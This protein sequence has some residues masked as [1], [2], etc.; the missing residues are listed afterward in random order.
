MK[1]HTKYF[2]LSGTLVFIVI[3]A[4]GNYSTYSFLLAGL[5]LGF[6]VGVDV[7]NRYEN[8]LSE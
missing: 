1:Q 7:K 8:F 2:L 5:W 3:Q 4:I 6:W